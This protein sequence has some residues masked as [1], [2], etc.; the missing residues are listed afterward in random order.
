MISE[1]NRK[2]SARSVFQVAL[3]SCTFAP[4]TAMFSLNENNHYYLHIP[5]NGFAQGLQHIDGRDYVHFLLVSIGWLG[6]RLRNTS[7]VLKTMIQ[8]AMIKL[9]LNRIKK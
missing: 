3:T 6:V 4:K 5:G 9:M 1:I 2:H 8:L 7:C